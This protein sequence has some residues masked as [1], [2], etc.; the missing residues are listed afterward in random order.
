MVLLSPSLEKGNLRNNQC[1]RKRRKKRILGGQ[2]Q[3][4][5][6]H[7]R[8]VPSGPYRRDLGVCFQM[9][10]FGLWTQEERAHMR[11]GSS[12]SQWLTPHRGSEIQ[13]H[14]TRCW[15]TSQTLA[16]WVHLEHEFWAW[17]S[18][19]GELRGGGL[20][21]L[22]SESWLRDD[23]E[24]QPGWSC[25]VSGQV[26]KHRECSWAS[27]NWTS[28]GVSQ[29][30]KEKTAPGLPSSCPCPPLGLLLT[31]GMSVF[32]EQ[33]ISTCGRQKERTA[34]TSPW[35]SLLTAPWILPKDSER[36]PWNHSHLTKQN[37]HTCNYWL[38]GII[39][40]MS[41]FPPEQQISPEF[42]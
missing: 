23:F 40:S 15:D 16:S 24:G 5:V 28:R 12:R 37:F 20:H 32:P 9:M 8:A 41:V 6:S 11:Q 3:L 21:M 22:V 33:P 4:A 1:R 27:W 2:G 42:I 39:Y 29:P 19:S 25:H 18:R 14:I 13:E 7:C 36:R 31:S 10:D 35:G 26:P 38:C 30:G 34:V 17:K